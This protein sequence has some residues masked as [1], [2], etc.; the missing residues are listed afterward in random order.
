LPLQ[1]LFVDQPQKVFVQ[2]PLLFFDTPT[3]FLLQSLT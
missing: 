1:P 3:A 2:A